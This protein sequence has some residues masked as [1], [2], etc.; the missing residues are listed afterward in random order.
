MK[1]ILKYT[2]KIDDRQTIS[3]PVDAKPLT[4]AMQRGNLCLWVAADTQKPMTAFDVAVVGTGQ[5]IPPS[6]LEYVG[7][8]HDTDMGFVWHVFVG[9]RF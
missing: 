4:V 2:L 8:A 3:M 5:P 7:T 6:D 1:N 9:V